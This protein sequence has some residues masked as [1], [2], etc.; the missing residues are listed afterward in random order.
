[1]EIILVDNGSTDDSPTILAKLLENQSQIR[2]VRVE[3]NQGYGYGIL[4]GL[5]EAKGKIL[6]WTHADMQTD[7]ADA[8]KGLE[9]FNQAKNYEKLFV[10]GKRYGRPLMDVFFTIGMAVFETVLLRKI[11]WDINAQPTMFSKTFF[12]TWEN[13]PHDFS[14]DL[15]TYYMAKKQGYI[16]KRFNVLF[17][18]RA[19]GV[20][21][22]NISWKDKYKFIKRTFEYS[23]KL[24]T[25]FQLS[26]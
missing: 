21:H 23:L 13:P 1:M 6:A 11:L 22:W 19:Y 18:E 9:F 12:E 15:Y 8:I 2:T 20:S 26:N 24:K 17:G 14:L 5:R 16:V 10:K 3:N 7:P 25:M 4:A